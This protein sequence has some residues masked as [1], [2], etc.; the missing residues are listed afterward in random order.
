MK[1]RPLL[2]LL[3]GIYVAGCAYRAQDYEFPL[4]SIQ[5]QD[6]NGLTETIS[7]PERLE[8]YRELDYLASQP[9]RK[10]IRIFKQNGKWEEKSPPIIPMDRSINILNRKICVHLAP[11]KN[12]IPMGY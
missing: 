10:I 6:R 2:F 3:C 4:A 8:P 12:G 9:Y 7:T 1:I 5:I 11:T